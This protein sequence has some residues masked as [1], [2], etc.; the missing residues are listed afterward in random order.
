MTDD[1]LTTL[2]DKLCAQEKCV[3]QGDLCTVNTPRAFAGDE[4]TTLSLTYGFE[5]ALARACCQFGA[6]STGGGGVMLRWANR[7]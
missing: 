3:R 6:G 7:E 2:P 4:H 5:K 1:Y